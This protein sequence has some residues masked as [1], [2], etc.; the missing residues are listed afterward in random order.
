MT[1]ERI[2]RHPAFGYATPEQ[3]EKLKQLGPGP[4]YDMLWKAI[5]KQTD[6]RGVMK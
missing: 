6:K 2:P 4:D 3:I 1:T 5:Q